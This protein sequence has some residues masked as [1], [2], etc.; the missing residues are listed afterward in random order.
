MKRPSSIFSFDNL[1]LAG[2]DPRAI[3]FAL[4]LLAVFDV[5]VARQ[6]WIWSHV[7]RS[8]AGIVDALESKVIARADEPVV[9]FM[10]SSRMRDAVI[11]SL[12]AQQLGLPPGSVLNLGLNAGTPFDALVLYR[13]NRAQL[14][15]ARV[16][17]FGVEDW[18]LNA[19][20]PPNE[21]D[22]RFA[23][24]SERLGVFTPDQTASMLLGWTWGAYDARGALHRY[25]SRL[26][27]DAAPEL[28]IA[29]D[30]RIQW[31]ESEEHTGP[32]EVSVEGDLNWMYQRYTPKRG[33]M[34]HL[35]T[36]IDMAKED[37]LQVVIVQIPWRDSYV[38]RLEEK[39]PDAMKHYRQTIA[40][41]T[42]SLPDV[43][44]DIVERAST[45][46]IPPTHYYDYGHLTINGAQT[47]TTHLVEML[48][49][50]FAQALT[51]A[52]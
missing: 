12:A 34:D 27:Y 9:L 43:S 52:E 49:K 10:G 44:T 31:R 32:E 42:G 6:D 5:A 35:R 41:F 22:R 26:G 20:M 1:T 39:Y 46:N 38:N 40:A 33:R 17:V 23:S 11:P 29:A 15:R 37:G 18:Y 8:Q 30:G 50:R 47:M 36:L 48:R 45:L 19:G 16:L 25:V 3:L 51:P 4:L 13:R 24:L 2:Y 21:R 7:P 28:A 14:R